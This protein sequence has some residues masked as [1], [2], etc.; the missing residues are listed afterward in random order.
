MTWPPP[1]TS[2]AEDG[3]LHQYFSGG[4]KALKEGEK[5]EFDVVEALKRLQVAHVIKFG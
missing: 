1:R 2:T 5:V 3:R 4:F